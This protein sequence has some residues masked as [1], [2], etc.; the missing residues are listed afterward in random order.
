MKTLAMSFFHHCSEIGLVRPIR[1][2][3]VAV[4]NVMTIAFLLQVADQFNEARG[5]NVGSTR[6]GFSC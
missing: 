6:D 1:Q 5:P 3:L 4:Y 2:R